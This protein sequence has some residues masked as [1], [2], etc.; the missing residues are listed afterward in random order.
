MGWTGHYIG[1]NPK[2]KER[3]AEVI[4]QEGLNW[5]NETRK[6]E[7]VDSA[8]VGSV[9]YFAIRCTCKDTGE[10]KVIGTVCLTKF[11]KGWFYI[12]CMDETMGPV[13]DKC[14]KRIINLLSPTDSEFALNWRKRC[15]TRNSRQRMLHL[16][17]MGT[18]IQL[19]CSGNPVFVV[20]T[21]AGRRMYLNEERTMRATPQ[22]I[23]RCGYTVLA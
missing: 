12:K 6:C 21:Y 22:C 10:T 20:T 16:L 18:K 8:L 4:H 13:E 19:H 11:N 15:L 2:G 3:L 17:P 7:V 9:C 23:N 14:P 1:E 5:E